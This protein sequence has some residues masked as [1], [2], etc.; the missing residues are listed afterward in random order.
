M[1]PRLV[2]HMFHTPP[3]Q[4]LKRIVVVPPPPKKVDIPVIIQE[5]FDYKPLL[6]RIICILFL[7]IS[8]FVLYYR[9]INKETNKDKHRQKIE[10]LYKDINSK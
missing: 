5:P 2:P 8:G 6:I 7:L 4:P 3:P 9:K 1:K 10:H